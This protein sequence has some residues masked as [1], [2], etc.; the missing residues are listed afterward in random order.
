MAEQ[1][2]Q[3]RIARQTAITKIITAQKITS[4]AELKMAL[5]ER[6]INTTQATLS[7][8]L[9]ELRA[10]KVRDENGRSTYTIVSSSENTVNGPENGSV[11][12]CRKWCQDLLVVAIHSNNFVMLRTPAGAAQ[13]LASALDNAIFPEIMGTIA[14]DDTILVMCVDENAAKGLAERLLHFAESENTTE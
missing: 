7:R 8:D 6:G 4:Q 12:R 1:I 5:A 10:T 3:T 9:F 14:G 13:L 11:T 2:P